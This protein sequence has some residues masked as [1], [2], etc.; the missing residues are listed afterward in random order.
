[1]DADT[2]GI[3]DR[4]RQQLEKLQGRRFHPFRV[5]ETLDGLIDNYEP[6]A[7]EWKDLWE[8]DKGTLSLQ[9]RVPTP[10]IDRIEAAISQ[11]KLVDDT[12]ESISRNEAAA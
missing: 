12:L 11:I 1:M 3:S 8:S 2:Q 9:D 6:L 5:A 4:Q 7:L 10:V